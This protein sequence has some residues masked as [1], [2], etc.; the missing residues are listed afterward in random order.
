M[1]RVGIVGGG[2]FGSAMACVLRRNGHEVVLWAREPFTVTSINRDRINPLYLPR[3]RL[4][5][6]IRAT[7]ELGEAIAGMDFLL[8]AVPAQ[9]VRSVATAMQPFVAAGLPIVSCAK[10]IERGSCA[11]MPE[12][13]AQAIP[14]ASV[15]VLSGPAFAREVAADLPTGVTFACADAGVGEALS[16]AIAT[17]N[18]CTYLCSDVMGAAVGG[19]MKNVLAIACGVAEGRKLGA[20]ARAT[21]ITRGLVEM[22]RLGLAKGARLETFM[23]LSGIGDLTLTC[24]NVQSRNMSLG[25]ALGEGRRPADVLAERREVTEGA[26]SAEAIASLAQRLGVD[27]PI[28][29]AVD[30]VLNHGADV[31]AVS[32]RLIA[33]PWHHEGVMAR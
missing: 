23:G 21:L 25:V 11:L 6:D 2:A 4:E 1:N 16:R 5:P 7:N 33:H 22:A 8:M 14:Q 12:V 31:D 18:F 26:F 15:A 20:N 17:R 3:I 27:M 30:A 32:A 13:L 29:T 19:A 9:F 28:A 24:N 10:G